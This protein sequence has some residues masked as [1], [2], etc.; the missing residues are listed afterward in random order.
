MTEK[1]RLIELFCEAKRE[2]QETGSWSEW[3]AEYLLIYGVSV[4][5]EKKGG[6]EWRK[7]NSSIS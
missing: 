5:T 1:E 4:Q 2:D 6:E 7:K 3:L